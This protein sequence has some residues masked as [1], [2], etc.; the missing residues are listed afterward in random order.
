MALKPS[1]GELIEAEGLALAPLQLLQHRGW[2]E[3]LEI[4]TCR[5]ACLWLFRVLKDQQ[6]VLN[7]VELEGSHGIS[8][9]LA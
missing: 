6:G 2:Q 7:A 1:G 5:Y 8:A 4:D 9:V 3:V